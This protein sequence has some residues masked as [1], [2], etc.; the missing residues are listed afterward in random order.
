[1]MQGKEGESQMKTRIRQ[2]KILEELHAKKIVYTK[3]LAE[4]FHVSS[5]TIRR[6]LARLAE[7]KVI[8]LLTGGATLNDGNT[9]LPG[10]QERS[11]RMKELKARI[12]AACAQIPKEGNS[13][14]L[15]AGTTTQSIAMALAERQNLVVMTHSLAIMEILSHAKGIQLLSVSGIYNEQVGGFLGDMTRRSIEEFHID[16]GFLGACA[17]D[18]A[19]GEISC[20]SVPD[21]D[22]KRAIIERS[23]RTVAVFDHTKLGTAF[24]R[25]VADLKD[26]D[27]LVTD[28]AADAKFLDRARR[29][30]IEVITA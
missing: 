10:T 14:Y 29:M 13:I 12:G 15:D 26:I 6:D 5:M 11:E 21:T 8:T 27:T 19:T 28:G 3:T 25:K 7:Q 1:M 23:Y 18:T 22:L 24:F 17:I 16:I 4:Q 20:A 2:Q 30:G 9:I